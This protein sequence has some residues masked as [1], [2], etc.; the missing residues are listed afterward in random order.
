MREA[1]ASGE[2]RHGTVAITDLQT[3]GRGRLDRRW[4]A[5][6]GSALLMS[7]LVD[8]DVC[9]L[10]VAKWPMVSFCMA[11][12]VQASANSVIGRPN[13][14]TLKWPNDVIVLNDSATSHGPNGV[15][16]RKMGGILVEASNG[17]LI[18]GCGVNLFRPPNVDPTLG[19]DAKPIWLNELTNGQIS[20]DAFAAEVLSS[21]AQMLETLGR[22]A[23]ELVAMYRSVLATIGW[24]VRIESSG[25]AWSGVAV[26]IDERGHLVVSN[27]KGLHHVEVSEVSHVRPV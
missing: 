23:T 22:S 25:S 10:E 24:E 1:V 21:F 7:V 13:A 15:T 12:A 8:A 9:G 11:Y 16:Y 17:M 18:V 6:S 2:A 3:A 20:R 19:V 14:V 5:P 4:V 27:D 26:D